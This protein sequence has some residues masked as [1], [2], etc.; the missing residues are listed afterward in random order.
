MIN[1]VATKQDIR[2]W[3]EEKIT[4]DYHDH[5]NRP[6]THLLVCCDLFDFEDYPIY[7]SDEENVVDILDEIR[8]TN[9][10]AIGSK[11]MEVY[12][13]KLDID[14]QLAQYKTWNVE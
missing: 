4:P 7:V 3:L 2:E 14:Q 9:D 8:H 6:I 12:S 10:N 1:K 11:V 5:P 13:Y